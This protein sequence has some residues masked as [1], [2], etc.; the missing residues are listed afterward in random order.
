MGDHACNKL[1][2]AKHIPCNCVSLEIVQMNHQTP[3]IAIAMLFIPTFSRINNIRDM[4][5][6]CNDYVITNDSTL[7]TS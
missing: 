3:I 5:H 7:V 6:K 4:C 2:L 1:S